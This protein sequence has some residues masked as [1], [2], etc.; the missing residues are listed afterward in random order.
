LA[1]EPTLPEAPLLRSLSSLAMQKVLMTAVGDD[2]V[3]PG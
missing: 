2:L 3:Q 1:V